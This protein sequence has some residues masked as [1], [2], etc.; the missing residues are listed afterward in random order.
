PT[1]NDDQTARNMRKLMAEAGLDDDSCV[2]WNAVPWALQGRR[3]PTAAEIRRGAEYLHDLYDLITPKPAVVAMGREAQRACELAGISATSTWHPSPLGLA[4]Q[5]RRAE[6]LDA[7]RRVAVFAD[8]QQET[9][10]SR[11]R[12]GPQG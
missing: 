4:R 5:G 10:T 6:V 12:T 2:F 9:T 11:A 3:P 7:L 8:G 1:K